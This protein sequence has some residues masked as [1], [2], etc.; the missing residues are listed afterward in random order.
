MTG[1]TGTAVRA[2][3]LAFEESLQVVTV[4]RSKSKGFTQE[5]QSAEQTFQGVIAP[6]DEWKQLITPGGVISST[7][8]V[9]VVSSDLIGS[10]GQGLSILVNDIVIRTDG[11][12]FKVVKRLREGERFGVALYT[13]TEEE[14]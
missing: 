3:L 9:L 4:T 14:E 8:P 5:T 2:A 12:R 7:Q 10:A 6:A 13:L 1:Y 11:Q